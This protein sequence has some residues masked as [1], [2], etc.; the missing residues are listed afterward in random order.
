MNSLLHYQMPI[1][2][3]AEFGPLHRAAEVF[4][5]AVQV[6]DDQHVLGR[7]EDDNAAAPAGSGAEMRDRKMERVKEIVGV[8][9]SLCPVLPPRSS[10]LPTKPVPVTVV[11][12]T[13]FL[14]ALS[15]NENVR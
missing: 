2:M 9:H 12:D 10:G 15:Y 8:G 13:R 5:V 14:R 6:A 3:G 1:G 11:P 4:H 7:V